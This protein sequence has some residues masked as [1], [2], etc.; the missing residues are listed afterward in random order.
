MSDKSHS[1]RDDAMKSQYSLAREHIVEHY[2]LAEL[3]KV[4]L[5]R[6]VRLEVARPEYDAFGYDL[7]LEAGPVIRHVQL[8]ATKVGGKRA[9]VDLSARLMNKPSACAI[10][11][12]FDVET[13]SI[14][15]IRWFGNEAGKPLTAL[16]GTPARHSR[17]NAAGEKAERVEHYRV[18]KGQF[19]LV[20]DIET[21][22]DRLFS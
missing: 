4:M 16:S 17:A 15:A 12:H 18:N 22:A 6:G 7:I 8:K 19:S 9:H 5:F 10:W 13:F 2:L 14:E 20:D 3:S 1:P 11:L 21:L